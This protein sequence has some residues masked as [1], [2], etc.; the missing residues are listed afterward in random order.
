[1]NIIKADGVVIDLNEIK[2]IIRYKTWKRE[3]AIR[4][5]YNNPSTS[6]GFVMFLTFGSDKLYQDFKRKKY[7]ELYQI[8][9]NIFNSW[10]NRI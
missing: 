9:F 5:L 3:H 7:P 2:G 8:L 6:P 4:V 1:M 10:D